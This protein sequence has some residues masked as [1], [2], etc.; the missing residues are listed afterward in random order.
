MVTKY[1]LIWLVVCILTKIGITGPQNCPKSLSLCQGKPFKKKHQSSQ[2]Y[3]FSMSVLT[4]SLVTNIHPFPN[5]VF[6][7]FL[8][9]GQKVPGW[10]HKAAHDTIDQI[11]TLE[12]KRISFSASLIVDESIMP[13]NISNR[14]EGVKAQVLLKAEQSN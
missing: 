3:I 1:P 9:F 12:A 11:L 13:L 6:N 7:F 10:E 4:I 8:V 14:G 5:E 2:L